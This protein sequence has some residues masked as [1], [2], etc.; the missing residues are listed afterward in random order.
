MKSLKK[1]IEEL[2]DAV[3]DNAES[4]LLQHINDGDTTCLIFFLEN[5]RER[6]GVML[7]VLSKMLLLVHS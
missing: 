2:E 6:K 4:K 5:E 7:S 3:L 1:K